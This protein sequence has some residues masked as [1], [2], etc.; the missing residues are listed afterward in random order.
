MIEI[1]AVL[2]AALGALFAL[3]RK[4]KSHARFYKARCEQT[5]YTAN[6]YKTLYEKREAQKRKHASRRADE[7]GRVSAGHRDHFEHR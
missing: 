5:E 3:W 2:G 7:A 6:A 4:E 1:I